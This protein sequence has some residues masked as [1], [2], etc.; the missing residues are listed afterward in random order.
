ML[1]LRIE[2]GMYVWEGARYGFITQEGMV[3]SCPQNIKACAVQRWAFITALMP[4][5]GEIKRWSF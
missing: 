3:R 4:L 1:I 2:D 5:D